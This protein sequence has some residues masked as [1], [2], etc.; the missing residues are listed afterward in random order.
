MYCSTVVI[1]KGFKK[2]MAVHISTTLPLVF[3]MDLALIQNLTRL[4]SSKDLAAI[5]GLGQDGGKVG[6]E[7]LA[8]QIDKSR[9]RVTDEELGHDNKSV[10]IVVG[11]KSSRYSNFVVTCRFAIQRVKSFGHSHK[12]LLMREE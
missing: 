5:T 10:C 6:L 11:F 12:E 4:Y 8:S 1:N 7:R 2:K 3:I 9:R